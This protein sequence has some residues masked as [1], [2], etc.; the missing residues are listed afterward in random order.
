M[1]LAILKGVT[2]REE[3]TREELL[4]L[5]TL[6]QAAALTMHLPQDK[7]PLRIPTS[8]KVNTLLHLNRIMQ[9]SHNMVVQ[10]PTGNNHLMGLQM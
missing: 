7:T 6:R 8:N 9:D 5:I 3:A 2:N 10:R 4:L 1:S